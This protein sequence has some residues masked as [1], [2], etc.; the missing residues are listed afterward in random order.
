LKSKNIKPGL[1]SK[2]A[3]KNPKTADAEAGKEVK[4]LKARDEATAAQ[5]NERVAA[6]A[7]QKRI[8]GHQTEST[9]RR[10]GKRDVKNA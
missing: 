9:R 10:Q 7:G 1:I 3:T 2:K 8:Q 5:R 4:R 6:A